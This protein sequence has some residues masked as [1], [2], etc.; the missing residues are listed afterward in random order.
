[1]IMLQDEI[2][3]DIVYNFRY[4]REDEMQLFVDQREK[5][6]VFAIHYTAYTT[7]GGKYVPWMKRQLLDKGVKFV[8]RRINTVRDV[9]Y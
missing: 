4:L 6:R 5:G 9:S 1:M 2:Y 3:G 7:E 8:Q